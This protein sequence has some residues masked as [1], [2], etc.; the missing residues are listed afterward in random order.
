MSQKLSSARHFLNAI[1]GTEP[2]TFQTFDDDK[3]RRNP[4][5]I[6][7]MH[8]TLAKHSKRLTRLNDE[9]AGIFVM[10][11]GGDLKGRRA[12]NVVKIR[13]LFVDLD[14]SP[15]EPV[16]NGPLPPHVIVK[17]SPGRYHAYWRVNDIELNEFRSIQKA[18]ASRF[19][20]DP[21]VNDLPRVMRIPGFTHQ[22][23]NPYRSRLLK[24]SQTT[25]YSREE[26]LSAFGIDPAT[27]PKP[28]KKSRAKK[29]EAREKIQGPPLH[30]KIRKKIRLALKR[31]SSVGYE[32]WIKVGMA[33]HSTG[34]PEAYGLWDKWSR[35]CEEKY[36]E[37]VQ[38][39]KWNSFGDRD[40]IALAM[41]YSLAQEKGFNQRRLIRGTR[42][43]QEARDVSVKEGQ[44][45]FRTIV[46]D[47][48]KKPKSANGNR[49]VV[50]VDVTPGFGKT[51]MAW[52]ELIKA[53]L[54]IEAYV[55][56]HSLAEEIA[57]KLYK[58]YGENAVPIMGRTVEGM[59]A[60]RELVLDL[61]AEGIYIV[62]SL[63]CQK[64]E[65][66]KD[67]VSCQFFA[68]CPY[69]LQNEPAKIKILSH[70]HLT[71]TRKAFDNDSPDIAV[72]DERFLQHVIGQEEWNITVLMRSPN[73]LIR[74]I[75]QILNRDKP[76]LPTLNK[77]F[78]NLKKTT[79]KLIDKLGSE[80]Q[81]LP[82]IDPS[83]SKNA[84]L[85]VMRSF[86]VV[87]LNTPLSLLHTLLKAIDSEAHDTTAI[88]CGLPN[89]KPGEK[90][91]TEPVIKATW[92]NLP[93]RLKDI[94]ILIIDGS[95]AAD[96]LSR[97]FPE[98]EPHQVRVGRHNLGY[99][100]QICSTALPNRRLEPK[101]GI[102]G[103]TTKGDPQSSHKEA[104]KIKTDIERSLQRIA[105]EHGSL[106][107]V[108]GKKSFMNKLKVPKGTQ[109]AH[110]GGILGLN[111]WEHCQWVVVIGRN[112]P[113]TMSMVDMAR[114][115][116]G[117]DKKPLN[118]EDN[119]EKLPV[120]YQIRTGERCGTWVQCHVDDRVQQFIH[121]ARE[122]ESEQS[123]D[124]SRLVH[125]SNCPKPVFIISNLPLD[126]EVDELVKFKQFLAGKPKLEQ[127]WE[128]M[129]K[130]VMP[131]NNKWVYIN[132]RDLFTNSR[133]VKTCIERERK[134]DKFPYIYKLW[135]HVLIHYKINGKRGKRDSCLTS[136]SRGKTKLELETIHQ[137]GVALVDAPKKS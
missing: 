124:R 1:A 10:V 133:Q 70:A 112:Q 120:G 28:T 5:L 15:I 22:K 24:A 62:R 33:L 105:S 127:V 29:R 48:I 34:A 52:E 21:T 39:Y 121:L 43:D 18:L 109:K 97:L 63:V 25:A 88:W 113:P 12:T 125:P 106:G 114:A 49:R 95:M 27:D 66:G 84:G 73:K 108:V 45:Q 99:V 47:L 77:R 75:A 26:F 59:C 90:R 87:R 118:T 119:L 61:N 110:F 136:L 13:C 85:Q 78:P 102:F 8:G 7:I 56:T 104:K 79:Q 16:K 46:R 131:L 82:E 68:D 130:R 37:D 64:K 74:A 129:G 35:Q 132:N 23:G 53:D 128:R 137:Q 72:I 65:K 103:S 30:K 17:S 14:G 50:A 57:E 9:G 38:V 31:V 60:K 117:N 111:E 80:K 32:K 2:V 98:I 3:D 54:K 40:G 100:T 94:P 83:M 20:S 42:P 36:D 96:A 6:G 91:G 135:N 58:E 115:F 126:I 19:D 92:L 93:E 89:K 71:H 107:L 134:Y 76:L 51:T 11:N 101:K 86:N 44:K 81:A 123:I 122:N 116:Y 4:E 55:P 69:I 67:P 41:L